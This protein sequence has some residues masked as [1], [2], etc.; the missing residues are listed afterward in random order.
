MA[1]F[2]LRPEKLLK[3]SSS[4]HKS[5]TLGPPVNPFIRANQL[6]VFEEIKLFCRRLGRGTSPN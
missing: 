2:F 6:G 4:V 5:I 3:V 1:W